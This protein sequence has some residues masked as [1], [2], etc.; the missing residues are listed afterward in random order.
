VL[1]G[2]GV[3]GE[4]DPGHIEAGE[5]LSDGLNALILDVPRMHQNPRERLPQA[6]KP[7]H[8]TVFGIQKLINVLFWNRNRDRALFLHH[9]TFI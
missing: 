9:K 8:Q 2:G 6:L 4:E 1:F 5:G 7:P 3:D